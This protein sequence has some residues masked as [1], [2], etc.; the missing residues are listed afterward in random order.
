MDVFMLQLLNFLLM[1]LWLIYQ[2]G[3]LNQLIIV[4][5]GLAVIWKFEGNFV[6]K[7]LSPHTAKV[8]SESFE[9]FHVI[10]EEVVADH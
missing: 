5:F 10:V 4:D 7:D 2:F 1:S 6:S 3:E 9:G 8:K